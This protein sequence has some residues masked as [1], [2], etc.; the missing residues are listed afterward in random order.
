M[1][2]S[3]ISNLIGLA[4]G[5]IHAVPNLPGGSEHGDAPTRR[6]ADAKAGLG[7]VP[8]ALPRAS[9]MN[10]RQGSNLSAP[11]PFT[12]FTALSLLTRPLLLL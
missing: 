8:E 2:R 7:V 12:F 11:L 10:A 6:S 5:G 4:H 3:S 9:S 1:R